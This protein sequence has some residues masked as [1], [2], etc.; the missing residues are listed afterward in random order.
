MKKVFAVGVALVGSAIALS[1]G[2]A[3]AHFE[4]SLRYGMRGSEEVR[5]LQEFLTVQQV[6]TGPVT[7]NFFSLTLEGV[8]AFQAR[9]GVPATGYFGP[10]S[11]ARANEVLTKGTVPG[12]RELVD[13]LNT[14]LIRVADLTAQLKAREAIATTTT[15]IT[16]PLA[17]LL[18]VTQPLNQSLVEIS[19]FSPT[20]PVTVGTG[21]GQVIGIFK[22]ENRASH[23]IYLESVSFTNAGAASS[24]VTYDLR[25]S[26]EGYGAGDTSVAYATA[27]PT[28]AFGSI[29]AASET[30]RRVAG[31]SSRYLTVRTNGAAAQNDTFALGVGALGDVA[32]AVNDTDLGDNA[33]PS[34][35]TTLTDTISGL[36]VNGLPAAAMV[37]AKN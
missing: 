32:Y 34:V 29:T 23:P 14:L 2:A 4:E 13:E 30:D 31:G 16:A 37:T 12:Q 36:A 8:K 33:N 27:N 35:N 15:T 17:P 18:S 6:Y 1:V 11:R 5:R 20:I 22:I 25:A 10:L 26:R 3:T 9:E 28:S 19:A 24:A 21:S 7:G